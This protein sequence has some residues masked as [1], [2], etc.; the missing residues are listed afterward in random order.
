M[1]AEQVF[2][3]ETIYPRA[4]IAENVLMLRKYRTCAGFG[5]GGLCRDLAVQRCYKETI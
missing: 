5:T 4:S 2:Y 1:V 3:T